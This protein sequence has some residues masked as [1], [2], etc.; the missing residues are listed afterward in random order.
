MKILLWSFLVTVFVTTVLAQ[1]TTNITSASPGGSAAS[2]PLWSG[3]APGALGTAEKDIP[4]LTPFF[5]STE[6]ANGAAMVICP[7]GG[8]SGLAPHE[9][10]G[11]AHWPATKGLTCF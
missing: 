6:S 8:Y 5:P 2:F 1:G 7:G 3:E 9:G 11:Y 4:T 10:Q